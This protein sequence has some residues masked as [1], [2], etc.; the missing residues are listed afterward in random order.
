[1]RSNIFVWP[2]FSLCFAFACQNPAPNT[3]ERLEYYETGEVYRRAK[4]V[5]GKLEGC[6]TDYYKD[7]KVLSERYF[8]RGL[9]QGRTVF[10]YPNGQMKE[11]QYFEAGKKERGDTL[12]YENGNIQFV[13]TLKDDKKDG[14]LR[15]WDDAGALIYEAKY[16]MDTLIEVKGQPIGPNSAAAKPSQ[17]LKRKD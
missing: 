13:T 5:D 15:K 3:T 6:M 16:S 1:M 10:Y 14:Y 2:I 9:Q 12:W 11:V 8:E 17:V 4:L 7:G